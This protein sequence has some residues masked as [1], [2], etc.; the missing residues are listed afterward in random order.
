M[1]RL[2]RRLEEDRPVLEAIRK[3]EEEEDR[4]PK[5]SENEGQ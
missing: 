1:E 5:Q 4:N 3:S 2:N